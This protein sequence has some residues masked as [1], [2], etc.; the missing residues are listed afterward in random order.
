M[1]GSIASFAFHAG[2]PTPEAEKY[3][4]EFKY[5]GTATLISKDVNTITKILHPDHVGHGIV[6]PASYLV[7]TGILSEIVR[8]INL[9]EEVAGTDDQYYGTEYIKTQGSIF[10]RISENLSALFVMIEGSY[11]GGREDF[12]RYKT[13]TF[14]DNKGGV[15]R[16]RAPI[17]RRKYIEATRQHAAGIKHHR[18]CNGSTGILGNGRST[19]GLESTPI[20]VFQNIR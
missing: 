19:R 13:L 8:E 20:H 11:L 12:Y 5:L 6:M 18:D 14:V 3:I 4:R 9:G 17:F 7:T 1:A 2:F 10:E 15:A 16:W